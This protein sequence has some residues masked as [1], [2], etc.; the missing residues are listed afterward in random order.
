MKILAYIEIGSI[1]A[2]DDI[3]GAAIDNGTAE[4]Y[5]VLT[6]DGAPIMYEA[7]QDSAA[8]YLNSMAMA[9]CGVTVEAA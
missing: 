1:D 9:C 8:D 4:K 6:V 5:A 7:E 2:L 3:L